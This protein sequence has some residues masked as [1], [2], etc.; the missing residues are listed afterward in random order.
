SMDRLEAEF[1]R[2]VDRA[3]EVLAQREGDDART[4][5]ESLVAMVKAQ[6]AL[7]ERQKA[8]A[9]ETVELAKKITESAVEV[10]EQLGM[11]D[12]SRPALSEKPAAR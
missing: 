12:T 6:H 10:M 1:E 2:L 3:K 5:I 7:L 4:R 9:T 11:R 8:L